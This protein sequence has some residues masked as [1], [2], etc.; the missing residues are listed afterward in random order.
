VICTNCLNRYYS[1][2]P[3][4]RQHDPNVP[5]PKKP[6]C[7]ECEAHTKYECVGCDD[8]IADYCLNCGTMVW[9]PTT[10]IFLIFGSCVFMLSLLVLSIWMFLID[11]FNGAISV[12]AFLF[13]CLVFY[14]IY[15]PRRRRKKAWLAWA[16]E[17]GYTGD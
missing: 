10:H 5:D 3:E 6:W 16:R 8:N 9:R 1:G 4:E 2:M 14:I 12:G 13:F 15:I 11:P 17:C 7:P